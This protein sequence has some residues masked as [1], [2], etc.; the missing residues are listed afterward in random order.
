M[1]TASDAPALLARHGET[2]AGYLRSLLKR[3][4]EAPPRLMEAVEYSLMAGGKRLRPALV[5]ENIIGLRPE[6]ALGH[7]FSLRPVLPEPLCD[8][9]YAVHNLTH[10]AYRFDLNL[11]KRGGTVDVTVRFF[12]MPGKTLRVNG[13]P[14]PEREFTISVREGEKLVIG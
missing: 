11:K 1:A 2:V 14:Q 10:G 8:G 13:E 4:P 9:R 3:Y 12:A 5:L 7:A 6:D